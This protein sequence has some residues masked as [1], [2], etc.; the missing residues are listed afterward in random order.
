VSSELEGESG[1]RVCVFDDASDFRSVP[2]KDNR[3]GT[4]LHSP[5]Q[6]WDARQCPDLVTSEANFHATNITAS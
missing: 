3:P 1:A 2:W 4:T 6:C 5:G